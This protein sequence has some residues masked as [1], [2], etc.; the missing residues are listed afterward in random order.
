MNIPSFYKNHNL[1]RKSLWVLIVPIAFGALA[2]FII[3]GPRA[4]NPTNI[5][6]LGAGDPLTHFLG[7]SIFRDSPWTFP[8]GANPRYGIELSNSIVFSDSLP[9]FAV[10]FKTFGGLL[11]DVFQY[12]GI[13]LLLC[14]VLQALLGWKLAGLATKG[15]IARLG[16]SGLFV[17]SPPMLWRL[18]GHLSLV[19]HF[20][21]LAALYLSL[22]PQQTYRTALWTCTLAVSALVH[23][24][25]LFMVGFIWVADL[26]Q[27]L[28]TRP[29]QRSRTELL[30]ELSIICGCLFIVTYQAGYF[31]VGSAVATNGYG[32]YRMNALSLLDSSGWSMVLRDIP[33]AAGDYEGFNY[34]GLGSI[35]ILLF[36]IPPLL[37]NLGPIIKQL[38]MRTGLLFV[39]GCLTLLA[40]TNNIGIGLWRFD[41]LLPDWSA[42]ALGIFRASGRMFWPVFYAILFFG[43]YVVVRGYR[44]G[45]AAFLLAVAL[46]VQIL[47][48]SSGWR[49]MR[50]RFMEP[51]R[52]TFDTP[53]QN[54]FW[55]F[56]AKH[57]G[58]VRLI[59]PRNFHPNWA[60]FASY[61]ALHHLST[62]A[63]YLARVSDRDAMFASQKA[64]STLKTGH[65]DPDFLYIIDDDRVATVLAHLDR[66]AD[67]LASVDGFN[68]LAPG[69]MKCQQCTLAERDFRLMELGAMR[70]VGDR[71]LFS[72][73]GEGKYYLL[74]GWSKVEE[75]GTWSDGSFAQIVIPITGEN[76]REIS[77]E[78]VAFVS[79]VHPNEIMEFRVNDGTP[80]VITFTQSK[81]NIITLRVPEPKRGP[82]ARISQLRVDFRFRNPKLP[83]ELEA[84]SDAR[85]LG[86]GLVAI[87][88]R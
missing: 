58:G 73:R 38:R 78:A 87:T 63:I 48:T 35:L 46:G 8:L 31:T 37:S 81:T 70:R 3:V 77:I 67:L 28:F 6:W 29:A 24:Y 13:W 14:F 71:L 65:F 36:S 34:L 42:K 26:L 16:A 11:P 84:D 54:P 40:I 61:A 4:L 64:E 15:L 85:R 7:W 52:S 66:H 41:I 59:S 9:L 53:L 60:T 51:P 83:E 76:P 72:Q 57:Y 30:L 12:F 39:C 2:F 56:A 75:W 80:I 82:D 22:R 17:F 86:I 27:I 19:G 1:S 23:P 33:E 45:V 69:W 88:L 18:H 5:A 62:D 10:P 55:T 79:S 74:N 20:P 21:L 47:D 43:I 44:R 32:Y 25:V 49:P 50:E 68:V